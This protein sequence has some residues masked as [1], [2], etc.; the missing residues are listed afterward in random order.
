MATLSLCLIWQII[1][2]ILPLNKYGWVYAWTTLGK[3]AFDRLTEDADVGKKNHLLRWSSFWSCG[4]VNKQKF[5]H[6]GH[7]KPARIHWKAD[8]LKTIQCF[9]RS[10]AELTSFGHLEAAIWHRWTIICGV[11][12]GISVTP[13]SQRQRF[14]R[15]YSWRHW[16]NTATH[17]R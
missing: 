11:P 6:L 10:E 4:Y 3:L 16:L 15:Q 8:A 14:K 17:S 13:T 12:S 1:S 9:W 7:R 5:S 2:F